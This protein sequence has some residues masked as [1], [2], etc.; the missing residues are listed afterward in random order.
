MCTKLELEKSSDYHKYVT[1]I[2][3]HMLSYYKERG[4]E[5]VESEKLDNNYKKCDLFILRDGEELGFIMFLEQNNEFY[6]SELHIHEKFQSRGYG[7]QALQWALK[8]AAGLG[9][10][11]LKVRVFSNNPAYRLYLR[12]GFRFDKKS[13]HTD[14]L[15]V[16]T[17]NK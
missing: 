13:P 3:D 5:W 12:N 1:T 15:A 14:Q 6:L 2:R 11:A 9:F 8:H 17:H 10:D 16:S 4:V 7:S